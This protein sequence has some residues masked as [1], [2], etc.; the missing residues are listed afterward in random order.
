M[1]IVTL[2]APKDRLPAALGD[3][4]ET[5]SLDCNF[6]SFSHRDGCRDVSRQSFS[7]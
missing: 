5:L 4:Q 3:Y 2:A 7:D 6:G 1:V